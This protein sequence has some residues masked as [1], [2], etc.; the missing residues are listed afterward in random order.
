MA[1]SRWS[2]A[3]GDSQDAKAAATMDDLDT[4]FLAASSSRRLACSGWMNRLRRKWLIARFRRW[5]R[6]TPAAPCAA[7]LGKAGEE[8]DTAGRR[9]TRAARGRPAEGPARG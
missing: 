7:W 1:A 5:G 8:G 4:P 2:A 9:R 6:E 3:S